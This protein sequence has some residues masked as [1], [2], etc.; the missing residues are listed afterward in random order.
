MEVKQIGK[1]SKYIASFENAMNLN[2]KYY[3]QSQ[4]IYFSS[5]CQIPPSQSNFLGFNFKLDNKT[6]NESIK[7]KISNNSVNEI[8]G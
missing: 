7:G 4:F 5:Y 1:P 8:M 3:E 6:Q 2:K